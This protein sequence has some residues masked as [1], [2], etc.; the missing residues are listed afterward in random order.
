VVLVVPVEFV[1]VEPG[2][3]IVVD[4]LVVPVPLE[5][6]LLPVEFTLVLGDT[7]VDVLAVGATSVVERPDV[8]VAVFWQAA[9]AAVATMAMAIAWNFM[10]VPSGLGW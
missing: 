10:D 7:F 4:E 3:P 1:V 6:V 5:L 8:R 2:A 9:S